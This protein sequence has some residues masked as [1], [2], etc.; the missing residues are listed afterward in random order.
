MGYNL[1]KH[2]R[3]G[4]HLTQLY[5][6]VSEMRKIGTFRWPKNHTVLNR[7]TLW[8]TVLRKLVFE[9]DEEVGEID[10]YYGQDR[11][12]LE[13]SRDYINAVFVA[14]TVNHRTRK[15]SRAFHAEERTVLQQL[16]E[17]NARVL[18][19]CRDLIIDDCVW[20]NKKVVRA[21]DRWDTLSVHMHALL[22][23]PQS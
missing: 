20:H 2:R 1:Q 15:L 13:Q 9:L 14:Y 5:Y 6:Q 12:V 16:M 8:H 19:E 22:I 11:D 21:V 18:K 17:V 3:L 7:F 23:N 10:I 4:L